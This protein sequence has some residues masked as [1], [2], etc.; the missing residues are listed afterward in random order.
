MNKYNNIKI[1]CKECVRYVKNP[2]FMDYCSINANIKIGC[3]RFTK[4]IK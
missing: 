1:N 3:I 4:D 2:P